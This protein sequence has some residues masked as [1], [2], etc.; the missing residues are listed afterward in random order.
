[1]YL[2]DISQ[3]IGVLVT[4]LMFLSP[5]FYPVTALPV[6]FRGWLLLNPLSPAI[7]LTRDVIYWGKGLNVETFVLLMVLSALTACLGF[8]WFQKTRKGFADVL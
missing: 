3:I 8:G 5:I 1:V 7:E 6:E 4:V 2:R